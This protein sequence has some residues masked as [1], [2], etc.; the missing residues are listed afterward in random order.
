MAQTFLFGR[1]RRQ[2]LLLPEDLLLAATQIQSD[3]LWCSRT[4]I[5]ADSSVSSLRARNKSDPMS[6]RRH[7]SAA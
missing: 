4:F 3:I 5:I 1:R 6:K 7:K 2:L